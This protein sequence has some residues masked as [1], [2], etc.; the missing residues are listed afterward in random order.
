ML[1]PHTSHITQPL[2]V[3]IFASY[4]AAWRRSISDPS[5]QQVMVH[6]APEAT[7]KRV[8]MIAQSL[9]AHT[10]AVTKHRIIRAFKLTGIYPP[11]INHFLYYCKGVT[12]VPDDVKIHAKEVVE[13]EQLARNARI[14]GKRRRNIVNEMCIVNEDN[15]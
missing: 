5:L 1:H 4:K 14:L 11:S 10:H 2:D 9:L 3:G 13:A 6:G 15:N 8:H 12:N 7:Q